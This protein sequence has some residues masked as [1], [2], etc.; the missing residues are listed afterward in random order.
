MSNKP[1][2]PFKSKTNNEDRPNMMKFLFEQTRGLQY[3]LLDLS[4]KYD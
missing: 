3:S 4:I 2:K 1:H